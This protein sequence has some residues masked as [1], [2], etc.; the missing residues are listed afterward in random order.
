MNHYHSS[1]IQQISG[2]RLTPN[3]NNSVHGVQIWALPA[4]IGS[5]VPYHIDYAEYIR[6]TQNVIVMPLYAGTVQCTPYE[7]KGGT[8]AVHLDGLK[9]YEVFGYKGALKRKQNENGDENED[10]NND[11][12]N[13]MAEWSGDDDDDDDDN[14]DDN[15]TKDIQVKN[16]WVSVPYQFNQGILHTGNLPHLSSK[17]LNV[18]VN[19]HEQGKRV[20]VGF[21]VFAHDVGPSVQQFPEHSDRFVKMVKL[22]RTVTGMSLKLGKIREN[23]ALTKLLVL[24]KREKVKQGWDHVRNLMTL[25]LLA[26][27]Q[28]KAD[29]DN[30]SESDDS[31]SCTCSCSCRCSADNLIEKPLKILV[32]LERWRNNDNGSDNRIVYENIRPSADDLHVHIHQL[33]KKGAGSDEKTSKGR[34]QFV[35]VDTS[36]C[37]EESKCSSSSSACGTMIG[38]SL[39]SVELYMRVVKVCGWRD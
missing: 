3:K 25:W 24:A 14:D 39:V 20:I 35:P 12:D 38:N 7:V 22:Q 34:F 13:R 27:F 37:Y 10:G 23:K 26:Q 6:Y 9:H 11:N 18:N 1:R 2:P 21:N 19:E 33:L 31:S 15:H 5:S 32:L 8:F 28:F 17:V 4:Q 36:A 29:I 30:S 16:G